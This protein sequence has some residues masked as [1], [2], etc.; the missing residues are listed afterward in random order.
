MKT[1]FTV[2]MTA[3]LLLSFGCSDD[4]VAVEEIPPETYTVTYHA[5]GATGGTVPVDS[6][7]YE[8]GATVTM[9]SN[10]GGL[11]KT[12]YTFA[13]WNSAADGNGST[14]LAGTGLTMPATNLTLYAKW[15]INQH[16]VT[17]DSQGADTA[18]TPAT[19]TVDY[20]SGVS[21]LPTA[22]VKAE[23]VFDGWYTA[24]NG[25]GSE[26]T[27]A[28]AVTA[29]L[30]VYAKWVY[31]FSNVAKRELVNV[32]GGTFT[33]KISLEEIFDHTVSGFQMAKYEVTYQLWYT[34]YS[35]ATNNGY[36]FSNPGREGDDGTV[37][38]VPT[39]AKLEPVTTVNWRDMIVWCN[40][41]SEMSGLNPFYCSDS[42]YTTPIKDS[43]DGSYDSSVNTTFGSYDNPYINWSGNGYR[44]PTEGEWQYAASYQ[45]GTNW[46]PY[47][48]ASGATLDYY[49]A[50][51]TGVVAWYND[52]SGSTTQNVGT[53]QANQL[54]IHDMSGNVWELCWDWDQ[55]WP[56]G[57]Q[58]D[59]R[60]GSY[61]DHR[62]RR[63]GSVEFGESVTI[64]GYQ[65]YNAPFTESNYFGFRVARSAE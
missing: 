15:T 25:G 29:D 13:G 39:M 21:S 12:G 60:S 34:V 28:T 24:E 35:W 50:S 7:E 57:S 3:M 10:S 20:N 65:T 40:A 9:L 22:P 33:Q 38:A 43:S 16:T 52:N 26:F 27:T 31:D 46:T 32:P 59:Y 54:G 17:F 11:V 49:H 62:I 5:N 48:H 53:R 8:T 63:G 18:A 1:I 45:D 19:M 47:N 56:S 44:L 41:Y 42:G 14:Y 2:L 55:N 64:V 58:I 51:A 6:G 61:G 30:T 36:T 23:Y 37:G 4:D